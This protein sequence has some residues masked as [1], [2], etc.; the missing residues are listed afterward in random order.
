MVLSNRVACRATCFTVVLVSIT[1]SVVDAETNKISTS[2]IGFLTSVLSA[3]TNFIKSNLTAISSALGAYPSAVQTI[4]SAF[5]AA[6]FFVVVLAIYL[7]DRAVYYFGYFMPPNFRFDLSSFE[8]RAGIGR[9]EALNAIFSKDCAISKCYG[10]IRAYLGHKNSDPNR[11]NQRNKIVKGIE[12]AKQ[13]FAYVKAYI[14]YLVFLLIASHWGVAISAFGAP[15]TAAVL[16]VVF[17]IAIFYFSSAYQSLVKYDL[18]SFI[19]EQLYNSDTK[20]NAG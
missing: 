10:A 7:V 12:T 2:A 14:V 16:F 19:W 4:A 11:I 9:V 17:T 1:Y 20:L 3:S 13:V 6:L 15:V 18:D 5:A 8:G